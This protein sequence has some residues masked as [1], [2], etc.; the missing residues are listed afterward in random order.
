MISE[1]RGLQATLSELSCKNEKLLF[2]NYDLKLE[3][4]KHEWLLKA[5]NLLRVLWLAL[6]LPS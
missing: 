5:S 6:L 1:V 4:M 2:D 3:N